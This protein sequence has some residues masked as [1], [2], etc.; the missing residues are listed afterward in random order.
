MLIPLNKIIVSHNPRCPASGLVENLEG[1]G[2]PNI[3]PLQLVHRLA[4]SESADDRAVFVRLME[5]YEWKKDGEVDP[6]SIVALAESRYK[7]GALQPIV[8][9]RFTNFENNQHIEKYGLVVGERRTLS[10]AYLHCKYDVK[11]EIVGTIVRMSVSDAIHLAWAE[12]RHRKPPTLV[13]TAEYFHAAWESRKGLV[14]PKTGRKWTI[15]QVAEAEN[16]EYQEFR[17]CEALAVYLTDAEKAKLNSGR[18]GKI[19]AQN[20]ASK[21]KKG[22]KEESI[23]SKKTERRRVKTLKQVED[24]FDAA[25]RKH[26]GYIS[27][28]AWVMGIDVEVAIKES[29]KRILDKSSQST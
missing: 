6:E 11:P 15:K 7:D 14:N 5:K 28:L 17:R 10:Q 3:T 29:D 20:I 16:E 18:I 8:V 24:E 19:A 22:N 25:Y 26:T 12:N 27:A 21:R 4:L 9:R 23:P 2:F 13:E 1:E